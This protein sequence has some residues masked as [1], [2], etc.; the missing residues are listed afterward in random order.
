MRAVIF[1][2]GVIVNIL[3]KL[4]TV[5]LVGLERNF[6]IELNI[7]NRFIYMNQG[8]KRKLF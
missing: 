7:L 3:C 1:R 5:D 2:A 4:K 6:E 8:F